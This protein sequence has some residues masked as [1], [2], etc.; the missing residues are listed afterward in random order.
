MCTGKNIYINSTSKIISISV[1]VLYQICQINI[2][3]ITMTLCYKVSLVN[4]SL[5]D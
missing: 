4:I 5:L 1:L 2:I 3:I